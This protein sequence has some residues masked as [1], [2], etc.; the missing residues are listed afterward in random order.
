MANT[1]RQNDRLSFLDC[2]RGI[3]ALAVLVEHAG[4]G[5]WPAFHVFVHNSFNFGKFGVAS[6]F[7]T[8]GF[9]IPF[10]LERSNSVK[11]FW[12]NRFFRLY[13]LYWLSLLLL[14][15]LYFTGAPNVF[16]PHFVSHLLRNL[17]VNVTMLQQF[18]GIPNAEGLYYTLCM[19]MALY[20]FLSFL[21]LRKWNHHSLRIAWIASIVL[22]AAG[23][24]SPL[25]LQRRIPMAG[26]FYFLCFFAGTCVYRHYTAHLSAKSL[27]VLLA[28][29]SITTVAEIYCNYVVVKKVDSTEIFTLWAVLL[30]W[31]AAYLLFL[32]AYS[33][34]SHK[35]PA[36]LIYLGTISYSVYLFHPS[37]GRV[38]SIAHLGPA[39]SFLSVLVL[40]ILIAS[41]T[42]RFVE[43]PSIRFGKQIQLRL[44]DDAE[45]P[46][47]PAASGAVEPDTVASQAVS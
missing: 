18:V 26:L 32:A 12:I 29:V 43:N 44:R 11:R 35:F 45:K 25:L 22:A 28:F 34:R 9:V 23:I 15:V 4:S 17:L 1:S 10:S 27:A 38:L 46:K 8:S 39:S 24:L 16:D 31:S 40:A 3:A 37:I 36:F 19:E 47:R 5:S 21:F 7:L 2:I 13:P 30:P 42:Y 33:F 20:I 6:F 41:L 14:V